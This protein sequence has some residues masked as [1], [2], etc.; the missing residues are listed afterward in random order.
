MKNIYKVSRSWCS[1]SNY[2]LSTYHLFVK[3][4]KKGKSYRKGCRQES[5]ITLEERVSIRGSCQKYHHF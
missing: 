3:H 5:T 4:S 1:E 2:Y